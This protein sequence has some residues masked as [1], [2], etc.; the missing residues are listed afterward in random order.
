MKIRVFSLP[1][2]RGTGSFDDT[3]V[4]TFLEDNEA[5]SVSDHMFTVD[6]VPTLALVVTLRPAARVRPPV[7]LPHPPATPVEVA[8]PDQPLYDSLRSWRNDRAK[9]KNQPA[10]IL[11]TNHQLA[12][13]ARQRPATLAALSTVP[14]VGDKRIKDFGEEILALIRIHATPAPDPAA[15][16]PA[17]DPAAPAP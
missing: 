4:Q 3:P 1:F 13:I 2:D 15:A 5:L 17:P 6:G 11:L 16:M 8:A 12:D 7:H 9:N 10:Y 14:G